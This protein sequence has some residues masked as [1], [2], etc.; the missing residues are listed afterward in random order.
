MLGQDNAKMK[1]L[2]DFSWEKSTLSRLFKDAKNGEGFV[3]LWGKRIL[4]NLNQ[5]TGEYSETPVQR[6]GESSLK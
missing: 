1:S 4:P 3:Q 2:K 6:V 5:K